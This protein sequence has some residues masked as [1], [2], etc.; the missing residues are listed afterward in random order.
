MN[1]TFLS[2]RRVGTLHTVLEDKGY[3]FIDCDGQTVF[4]HISSLD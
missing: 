2:N 3:G 1:K 4:A